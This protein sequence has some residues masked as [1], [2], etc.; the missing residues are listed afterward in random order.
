[1]TWKN[2]HNILKREIDACIYIKNIYSFFSLTG[3]R[4]RKKTL[5]ANFE[6]FVNNG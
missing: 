2:V 4:L 5:R 3:L 1:M 6:L